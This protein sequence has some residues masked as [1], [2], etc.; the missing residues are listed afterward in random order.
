MEKLL[1]EHL[2]I[3]LPY[4]VK[5]LVAGDEMVM[6]LY[7]GSGKVDIKSVLNLQ[8]EP[9]LRPLSDL[10]SHILSNGK[11]LPQNWVEQDPFGEFQLEYD[12]ITIEKI[13]IVQTRV[14]IDLVKHHYDVFGLIKYNLAIDINTII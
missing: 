1:I 9:I 6:D 12:D 3:Y 8:L 7:G 2:S 11:T 13:P 10:Y 14:F 5:I 4:G